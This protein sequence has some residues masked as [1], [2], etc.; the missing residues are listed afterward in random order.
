MLYHYN[1][2]FDN[3]ATDYVRAV[4]ILEIAEDDFNYKDLDL[5]VGYA[6]IDLEEPKIV[7]STLSTGECVGDNSTIFFLLEEDFEINI[8]LDNGYN[9]DNLFV[10]VP[11]KAVWKELTKRVIEGF[12]LYNS[13]T[14]RKATYSVN[15]DDFDRSYFINI[16]KDEKQIKRGRLALE[17]S[18][19]FK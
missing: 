7:I 3:S 10:F 12:Q 6:D 19:E 5:I 2:K 1:N 11:N 14:L 9:C 13:N 4:D 18:P 17:E 8:D 16:G 15:L